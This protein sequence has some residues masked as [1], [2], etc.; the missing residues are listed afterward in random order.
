MIHDQ[1]SRDTLVRALSGEGAHVEVKT[2]LDGVT[3]TRAGAR[4]HGI[5]KSIFQIVNH[6]IFWNAWVVDWLDGADPPIPQ[7]DS[8]S[9]PGA[10]GPA[11]ADEWEAAAARLGDLADALAQHARED[12]LRSTRLSLGAPKSRATMLH[13]IASHNSYHLGQIVLV[14][15]IVGAWPPPGGGLTW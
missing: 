4:P 13:T 15:R 12:D 1:E 14:R 2:A 7:Q 6:L 9:W 11:S 10:V 5:P 8:D 3:W